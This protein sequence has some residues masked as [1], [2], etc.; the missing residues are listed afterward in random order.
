MKIVCF[1]LA[2]ILIS[3]PV[4]LQQILVKPRSRLLPVGITSEFTCV[5]RDARVP[6]WKVNDTRATEEFNKRFLAMKGFFIAV[7]QVVNG[8]TTLLMR[9]NSSYSSVS[10]TSV[11]CSDGASISSETAYVL[12]ING[13]YN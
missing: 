9:V 7:N 6:H 12:T 8:N 5:I 10:N 1:S 13:K 4:C 2:L 11:T 3:H